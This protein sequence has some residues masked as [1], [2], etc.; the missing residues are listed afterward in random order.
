MKLSRRYEAAFTLAFDLHASQLRKTTTIPYIAHLI[1]VSGIVLDYGG[2]EDEAIAALLHDAA[3]D[4]GGKSTLNR[5]R[6]EFGSEVADIVEGCS[7][8]MRFLKPPWKQR[9]EEYIEHLRHASP[10]VCLVSAADK[11]HNVRSILADYREIGEEVWKRFS[12]KRDGSLW[13]YRTVVDVLR[14]RFR[15]PLFE[16]LDRT[17]RELEK[18]T[19]RMTE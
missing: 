10:S 6:K 15:H 17:I 18:L 8:T 16:E 4:Q 1:G 19:L 7:D 11:L 5:I 2:S 14:E 3:E 13:Y 9:K 12:G